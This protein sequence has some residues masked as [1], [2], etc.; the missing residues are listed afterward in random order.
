MKTFRSIGRPISL[1]IAG[2]WL[3]CL[4]ISFAAPG[5]VGPF[6]GAAT[7]GTAGSHAAAAAPAAGGHSAHGAAI[8]ATRPATLAGGGFRPTLGAG[9]GRTGTRPSPTALS[10]AAGA[11]MGPRAG[12]SQ[13]APA[14]PLVQMPTVRNAWT[15]PAN[16]RVSGG[17]STASR[18]GGS[19]GIYNRTGN[20]L[21]P[22]AYG[23]T[24]TRPASG[25]FQRGSYGDDRGRRQHRY[26]YNNFPYAVYYPYLYNNYGYG[27]VGTY[28]YPGLTADF[29]GNSTDHSVADLGAP[30][31]SN[32]PA[33]DY[34][35]AEPEQEASNTTAPATQAQPLPDA[36]AVGPQIPSPANKSSDTPQG[37]DS[38]VE[39][40]QNELSQRGY[41]A[42]K[43]DAMYGADTKEA[44]RRFQTDQRLPATGRINEATLHALHLD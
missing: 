15:D 16:L 14:R 33:N 32:V 26:Y 18:Q 13:V 29:S 44:I 11:T 3:V 38:L 27:G 36:P 28:G 19:V 1:M 9:T 17:V 20:H 4:P 41:F 7:T 35:Y 43:A 42:G 12:A 5:G 25:H 31:F 37:P 2:G 30:D 34:S 6:A 24:P 23:Y 40:V 21:Y 39:A 22:G 10:P 8:G